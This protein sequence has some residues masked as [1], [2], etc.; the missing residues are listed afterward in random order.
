[1]VAWSPLRDIDAPKQPW[2][3]ARE[4]I[5]ALSFKNLSLVH[6]W[7]YSWYLQ[8]PS[9]EQR[10][11]M[12]GGLNATPARDPVS[13]RIALFEGLRAT[14]SPAVSPRTARPSQIFI[15]VE[16]DLAGLPR[17]S[18]KREIETHLE[19]SFESRS[20]CDATDPVIRS[21]LELDDSDWELIELDQMSSPSEE[22]LQQ[23][24]TTYGARITL[25]F[26]VASWTREFVYRKRDH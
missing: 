23:G 12:S 14:S 26:G 2:D 7:Y 13:S 17:D 18:L 20:P 24:S 1:L 4:L 5:F 11:N 19:Q 25:N 9:I 3:V 6:Y 21:D 16:N 8:L 10:N 15:S 22:T